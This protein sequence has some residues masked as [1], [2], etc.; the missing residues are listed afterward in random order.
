MDERLRSL[1]NMLRQWRKEHGIKEAVAAKEL[2]VS[3]ATWGHWEEG[4]RFPTSENLV[5]LSEYT[6]IP[7]Q[8]F[9]CPNRNRCPFKDETGGA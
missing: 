5:A 6:E 4:T 2:G 3:V 8:H 7:I 1:S 9:F